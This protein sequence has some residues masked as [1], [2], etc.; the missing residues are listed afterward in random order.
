MKKLLTFLTI[1][2][3]TLC[4]FGQEIKTRE[5]TN[6]VFGGRY[7]T[8]ND[9]DT[10]GIPNDL[11]L[12]WEIE[13]GINK[14]ECRFEINYVIITPTDGGAGPILY[15]RNENYEI[16]EDNVKNIDNYYFESVL[17]TDGN[18]RKVIVDLYF[19]YIRWD[20][21]QFRARIYYIEREENG[22]VPF[23][24]FIYEFKK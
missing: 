5:K 21:G 6:I 16:I 8:I 3:L 1:I 14:N 7:D 15:A 2:F 17:N 12:I 4:S 11:D 24:Y 22:I 19:N 13:W 23:D 10:I 9:K 20:Y 18:P